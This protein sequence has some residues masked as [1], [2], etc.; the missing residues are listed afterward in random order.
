MN[1][2]R[3][4]FVGIAGLLGLAGCARIE[5]SRLGQLTPDLDFRKDGP[6]RF[7]TLTDLHLVDSRSVGI[8]GRA[9]NGI[10]NDETIDFVVLLGDISEHGSLQEMNLAKQALER[11]RVP[12]HVVPGPNDVVAGAENSLEFYQRVFK[13]SQWKMPMGNWTF[14]GLDTSSATSPSLT[15]SE[16]SLQW[17]DEQ[18][19]H[20]D[21]KR[22]LALC[23]HHPLAPGTKGDRLANAEDVLARFKN[24]NLRLV[25]SGHYHGNQEEERDGILFVTTACCSTTAENADPAEPKG[26]RVFTL[27]NDR[28]EHEFMTVPV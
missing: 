27:D 16:A 28:I 8:L 11:L 7:A 5:Q 6:L 14:I 12:H 23:C 3:R 1:I 9:I 26:Y 13:K 19:A 18:L 2:T 21:Q 22:P 24:H 25:N 4:E 20:T 10:N 15:L 17:L